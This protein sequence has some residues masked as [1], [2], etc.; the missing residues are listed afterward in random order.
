MVHFDDETASFDSILVRLKDGFLG[1]Y[2]TGMERFDSI[3]VRLKER[4]INCR[5]VNASSF[6]FH[7][8]S[9]KSRRGSLKSRLFYSFDS[10]LVRLK[11]TRIPS[12]PPLVAGFDSILVRLKD[13][14]PD[15]PAW[16]LYLFRFHTGSIKRFAGLA[17]VAQGVVSIPYWFD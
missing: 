1:L 14:S 6:R 11:A 2:G 12:S 10:I 16:Y 17:S 5:V 13:S 15:T 3:L 8:G 9:I 4:S 7:T